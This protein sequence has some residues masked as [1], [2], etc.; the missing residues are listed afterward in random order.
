MY[1]FE[2][3]SLSNG[4]YVA[5]G[6]KF[7]YMFLLTDMYKRSYSNDIFTIRPATEREEA[8]WKHN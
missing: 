5:K 1:V 7:K 4:S 8:Y 6:Q 2:A 3:V